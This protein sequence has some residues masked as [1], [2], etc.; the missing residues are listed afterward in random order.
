MVNP[1]DSLYYF[2]GKAFQGEK[3]WKEAADNFVTAIWLC[4]SDSLL[5]SIEK[6]FKLVLQNLPAMEAITL[7]SGYVNATKDN[8]LLVKLLLI[9]ADIYEDNQLFNEANDVYVTILQE[10]DYPQQIPMQ[11][12]I[13]TNQI[14]LEQ[15]EEAINTLSPIV[16]LNDSIYNADALF[17]YYLA[18]YSVN[19]YEIAKDALLKLYHDYPNHP[20]RNEI[21]SGLADVFEKENQLLL[22]WYFLN[23]MQMNSS[24]AQRFLIQKRITHLKTKIAVQDSLTDQFKYF[25]LKFDHCKDSNDHS[26]E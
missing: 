17:F 2:K 3:K 15:Y 22:S 1:T 14:F 12:K 10:T 6:E 23:E 4:R 7:L 21:L 16:A 8:E 25:E 11:M 20:K 24:E 19:R 26:R 5:S 9:M 13:A 18:N